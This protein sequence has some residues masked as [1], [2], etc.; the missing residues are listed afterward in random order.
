M[1]VLVGEYG[2]HFLAQLSLI[3]A[4]TLADVVG[5][6]YPVNSM[7]L[8]LPCLEITEVVLVVALYLAALNMKESC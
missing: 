2:V 3:Y 4:A 1:S 8:L 6:Q 5:K 7:I